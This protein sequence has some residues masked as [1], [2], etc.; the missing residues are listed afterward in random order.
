[1]YFLTWYSTSQVEFADCPSLDP[2]TFE[3]VLSPEALSFLAALVHRF[4]EGTNEVG[5]VQHS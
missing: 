5:P 1:M 3:A 4:D 2:Q